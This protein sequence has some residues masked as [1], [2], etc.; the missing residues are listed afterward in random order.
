MQTAELQDT[1]S[2]G[3][4]KVNTQRNKFNLPINQRLKE[5]RMRKEMSSQAVVNELKKRGVSIGHSTLQGYEADESSLNHRYPS[6]SVLLELAVFYDCSIDY[7]FGLT[8]EIKRPPKKRR[9]RT[10]DIK[11]ELAKEPR[12]KRMAWGGKRL[13]KSQLELILAQ[14]DFIVARTK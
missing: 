2:N 10:Y 12:L 13:T 11:K 3:F 9:V 14:I 8:D 5:A 7:L 6:I 1:Y 4:P